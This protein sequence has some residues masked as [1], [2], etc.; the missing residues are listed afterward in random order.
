MNDDSDNRIQPQPPRRCLRVDS[1]RTSLRTDAGLISSAAGL[2]PRLDFWACSV[3][4]GRNGAYGL[5]E[6]GEPFNSWMAPGGVL[7]VGSCSVLRSVS[8]IVPADGGRRQL[9]LDAQRIQDG[10]HFADLTGVLSLFKFNDEA[11]AGSG[12]EREVFLSDAQQ[13]AGLPDTVA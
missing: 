10:E 2:L 13:L 8:L 3:S 7:R 4:R 11:K 6:V 1:R 9:Q 12:C 5:A